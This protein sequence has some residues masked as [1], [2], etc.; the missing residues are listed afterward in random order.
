MTNE[1]T[2]IDPRCICR[3]CGWNFGNYFPWGEDG[4]SPEYAI[5]YCCGC[6]SGNEDS[7]PESLV[8]YRQ[9]WLNSGAK[10]WNPKT[11]PVDWDDGRQLQEQLKRV[12][13]KKRFHQVPNF[14]PFVHVF[15]S[16]DAAIAGGQKIDAL[17]KQELRLDLDAIT[18]KVVWQ[19]HWSPTEIALKFAS[20]LYLILKSGPEK[21]DVFITH[22]GIAAPHELCEDYEFVYDENRSHRW[23]P[24]CVAKYFTDK[25]FA[26]IQLEYRMAWLYFQKCP[27]LISVVQCAV[28][29][30]ELPILMWDEES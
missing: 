6:E 24:I 21:I 27:K 13:A 3:C 1:S 17:R 8:E 28:Q 4:D 30:S 5:C 9:N 7:C 14:S 11:K 25:V 12:P 2:S 26:H 18:G 16:P 20:H 29:E 23:S 15:N 19:L 10:W 22:E